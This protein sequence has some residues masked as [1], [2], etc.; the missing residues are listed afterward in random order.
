MLE[1]SKID[2]EFK[3]YKEN[4]V[5]IFGASIGGLTVKHFLDKL[6]IESVAFVDNDV[7]KVGD[8]IEGI[9]IIS[10]KECIEY[11]LSHKNSV[12][13]IGSIYEK[14]MAAQLKREGVDRYIFYSDFR[15]R[16]NQLD[17]LMCC[18]KEPSL[19]P[20]LED[21]EWRERYN[22]NA[23]LIK[24]YFLNEF[25]HTGY[26]RFMLSAPKVGNATI[27]NS[28]EKREKGI[29]SLWHSYQYIDDSIRNLFHIYPVKL[30]MGVRDPIKQNLSML[31]Q[32]CEN[33]F[34]DLDEYWNEGGDVSSIFNEY[35]IKDISDKQCW[36]AELKRRIKCD[37]LVQH[38][39][40]QQIQ[41]FFG[42]DVF[43]YPFNKEKGFSV[44]HINDKLDIMIYQLEKMNNIAAEIGDFFGIQNFELAMGNDSNERWYKDSYLKVEK[45]ISIKKEYY[46][47]CYSSKFIKHFYSE[48]DINKFKEK[49][50]SNVI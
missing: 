30:I 6:G 25:P 24:D 44:Y 22:Y 42:I 31:Y 20:F 41:P 19:K 50:S 11:I 12:V 39:F 45:N 2:K 49:W 10:V 27:F 40:E 17:R 28:L 36:F 32:I 47:N 15:M 48:K 13:Q 43:Q 38:F 5:L 21:L 9:K 29:I 34:W 16:V 3:I 4:D 37:Y 1:F 8:N 23:R 35:F 33:E 46:D 14:E 18:Q 26:I 7:N